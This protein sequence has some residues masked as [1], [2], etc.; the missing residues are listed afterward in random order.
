M[1]AAGERGDEA[2]GA[3]RQLLEDALPAA[4]AERL[5]HPP[6]GEDGEWPHWADLGHL[7]GS[8][9]IGWAN[10]CGCYILFCGAASTYK[11]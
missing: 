2:A 5:S 6:A 3:A 4:D 7:L 8:W 11:Y 9:Q 1:T 10:V